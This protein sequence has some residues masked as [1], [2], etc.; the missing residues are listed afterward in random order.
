MVAVFLDIF[1]IEFWGTPVERE[2]K[3]PELEPLP[4]LT[5]YH[6]F[7]MDVSADREVTRLWRIHKTIHQLVHDRGYVVSQAEL[8]MTLQE[9]TDTYAP[10]GS[11]IE[12]QEINNNSIIF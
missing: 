7:E 3:P 2:S 5:L 8:D 11:I 12:Y 10:S 9:F 4:S 1:C 6:S